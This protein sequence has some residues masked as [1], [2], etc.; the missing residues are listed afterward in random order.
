MSSHMDAKFEKGIPLKLAQ[1]ASKHSLSDRL[2]PSS[3]DGHTSRPAFFAHASP[4]SFQSREPGSASCSPKDNPLEYRLPQRMEGDI[5]AKDSKSSI[6]DN[7]RDA[8]RDPGGYSYGPQ[9]F[10]RHLPYPSPTSSKPYPH[11]LNDQRSPYKHPSEM[12]KPRYPSHSNSQAHSGPGGM[13]SAN[14]VLTQADSLGYG[15]IHYEN[16]NPDGKK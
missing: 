12:D 6:G 7:R 2:R 14:L 8:R 3:R 11:R 5:M 13:L 15:S 9:Y 16:R 1:E 4:L 10:H